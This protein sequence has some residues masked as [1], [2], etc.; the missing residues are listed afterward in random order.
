MGEEG[1]KLGRYAYR[2]TG[3][4]MKK[5]LQFYLVGVGTLVLNGDGGVS[6]RHRSS[7]TQ[8][9]GHSAKQVMSCFDLEG[10]LAPKAGGAGD[11]DL[12]AA[13]TF[14]LIEPAG[15][16][17]VLK[18]TFSLVPVDVDRF[19]MIST[20]AYNDTEKAWANEVVSGEAVWAGEA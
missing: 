3:F 19:W 11:N 8:L 15:I 4:V 5:N 6:G 10:Q 9:S 7:I 1:M 12:E 2:F 17:Q 18:A 13:I 14:R 16:E 20:G